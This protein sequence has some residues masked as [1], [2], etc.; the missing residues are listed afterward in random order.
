MISQRLRGLINLHATLTTLAIGIFFWVYANLIY[1]VPFVRLSREVNLLPYFLC[2]LAAMVLGWRS[3]HAAGAR[4]PRLP[5][6]E[7]AGLAGRQVM[8]MA[9]I[10]F[11]MMF[12]TQDRS[13][14]RLFLGTFLVWTGL[15][16]TWLHHAA[17]AWLAR[18]VYQGSRRVRTVFVGRPGALEAM[19]SWVERQEQL[20]I[21]PIGLVLFEYESGPEVSSDNAIG[22]ISSLPKLLAQRQVGQV[23]LLEL[24][25]DNTVARRLLDVCQEHGCRLLV[26]HDIEERF[27]HPLTTL[28]EEGHLFFTLHDEPLEEPINRTIKRTF[29]LAVALPVVVFLLPPL[30]LLIWVVQHFQAPGPLFHIRSRS[31]EKRSSFEMLKFRSMRLAPPNEVAEVRQARREDERVY[32]FG[33][34]MRRHSLD[35]FPQ[36][37]NVLRGEMSIV[38]PRPYMPLLDEEFRQLAKGYRTRHLVKPGITGL[39]QSEGFRGEVSDPGLLRR[40]HE[41]DLFYITH[42]SL[43][44]DIEIT[45]KT[46]WQVFFPPRSA[47]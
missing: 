21:E 7:A 10:I 43:W 32:P 44:L 46:C 2:V 17:P 27:G 26:H 31:G 38:G 35:E 8:L 25:A 39:A 16:L 20:G 3:V 5:L 23:I 45:L 11:S 33:R 22:D 40:R 28:E 47:Y 4:L 24:P 12:A 18:I 37:W 13:I 34:F 19:Q 14:S 29:D 1:H 42:W 15:S 30:C 36:F 9:L 6:A 41:M